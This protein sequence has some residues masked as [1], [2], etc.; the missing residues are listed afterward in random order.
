MKKGLISLVIFMIAMYS[1]TLIASAHWPHGDFSDMNYSNEHNGNVMYLVDKG[2]INGYEDGT[3][4]PNQN[5]TNRQVAVMIFRALKLKDEAYKA[6]SYSDVSP[7]DSAYREIAI[8]AQRGIFPKSDKFYP[9]QFITRE[10]MAQVLVNAFK[11]K[12]TSS[13]KFKD[14]QTTHT[15]YVAIQALVANNI[16]LG[17]ED[18][19]FKPNA[20]L[21]R[22]HFSTFLTRVLYPASRPT[23]K[24][25]KYNEG[26]MPTEVVGKALNY[27]EHFENIGGSLAF[28]PVRDVSYTDRYGNSNIIIAEG[29]YF[30]NSNYIG[31]SLMYF[32]EEDFSI[33]ID[34]PNVGG[35]YVA[36]K[37]P[38][39]SG[40]SNT[41]KWN[42]GTTHSKI[43]TLDGVVKAGS[44]WYDHVI[45]IKQTEVFKYGYVADYYYFYS[46]K[47]G[48]VALDFDA[49]G[50]YELT[51]IQ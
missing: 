31:Y 25:Y 20:L 15:A 23:V 30:M 1:Q 18:G 33:H 8:L 9:N 34:L 5:I 42:D 12:G 10:K 28:D 41:S 51:N 45:I 24:S 3:F 21:T 49:S 14:V 19:T 6:P 17:Y 13:K 47:V 37:F 26:L 11:L 39:K 32:E 46:P 29:H 43:I 4:K 40:L 7:S 22:A 35:K 50:S 27:K 44:K 36:F 16:T 48:L 38:L 2:I